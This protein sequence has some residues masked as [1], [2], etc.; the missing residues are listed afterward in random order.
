MISGS[1]GKSARAYLCGQNWKT[2]TG[3]HR[4]Q[5]EYGV[6]LL[7]IGRSAIS[8]NFIDPVQE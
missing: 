7:T 6:K 2:D 4:N 1:F 5:N 8:F 3:T